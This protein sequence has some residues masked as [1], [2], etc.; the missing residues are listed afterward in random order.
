MRYNAP[1][2]GYGNNFEV[3]P[4]GGAV[5][6]FTVQTPYEARGNNMACGQTGGSRHRRNRRGRRSRK[7]QGGGVDNLAPYGAFTADQAGNRADFDGSTLGLPVKFG[8]RRRR[9]KK[10]R[11]GCKKSFFGLF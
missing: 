7:H 4:S 2:A 10:T 11:K 1:T 6:G 8:G 5:P 3:L 9:G